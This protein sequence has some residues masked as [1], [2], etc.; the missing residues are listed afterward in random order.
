MSK[1]Y[2]SFTIDDVNYYNSDGDMVIKEDDCSGNYYYVTKQQAMD[3]FGL[4]EPKPVDRTVMVTDMVAH[5]SYIE[6]LDDIGFSD[7][8]DEFLHMMGYRQ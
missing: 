3:F 7:F 4:V 8:K 5:I 6:P 1:K 2:K